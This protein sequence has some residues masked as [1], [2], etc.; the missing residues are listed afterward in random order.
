VRGC[1]LRA[2]GT[3]AGSFTVSFDVTDVNALLSAL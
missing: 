1:S 2:N 3:F